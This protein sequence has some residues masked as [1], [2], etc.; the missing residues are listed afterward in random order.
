[1]RT[2]SI[3][4]PVFNG[5]DDLA[6]CLGSIAASVLPPA[7]CIVVDDGSTDGS[8]AVARQF[9]ATVLS[10]GRKGGGPARARNVGASHASSDILCFFDADVC[11]H[12]DTL[13]RIAAAFEADGHLDAVMGSYDESPEDPA[14]FSQ[15]KNLQHCFVH[16]RG[17]R[18]ASTFWTGCGAIRREVFLA[19]GGFDQTYARPCIE[20]V[21]LGYRLTASGRRLMLDPAI[22][23]QHRKRWTFT[24]LVRTDFFDRALPWTELILKHR[25][26]PNDLNL[27]VSQ[28]VSAILTCLLLAVMVASAALG[29]AAVAAGW[30]GLLHGMLTG[31][32]VDANLRL[33][34][35]TQATGIAWALA[36]SALAMAAGYHI[37]G[38]AVVA[39]PLA[40]ALLGLLRREPVRRAL[41][42]I[43]VL[44]LAA[45]AAWLVSLHAVGA[46]GLV[47]LAVVVAL[48]LRFYRFLA[49][50]GGVMFAAGSVPGHLLYFIYSVAGFALG[51]LRY[52]LG[53]ARA[54][55]AAPDE[56]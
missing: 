6:A 41:G 27:E 3:V 22:Q 38:A 16:H 29:G 23:V 39:A 28:R 8:V 32:W 7:E 10:S 55:A 13:G 50:R 25:N 51:T 19:E 1:M 49:T 34:R 37:F 47:L 24:G 44:G 11:L 2:L 52:H 20:D 12:P 18:R 4:I 40:T 30:L 26:L 45:P 21:E 54:A 56:Q 43:W 35:R 31:V 46:V 17:H 53:G 9:G 33:N 36:A 5:G 42:S 15:Y 48:N 14:F